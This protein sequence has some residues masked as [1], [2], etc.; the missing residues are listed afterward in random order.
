[1]SLKSRLDMLADVAAK[2]PKN[3]FA[4]YGYAMELA[5]LERLDEAA[6]AFERLAADLPDYVPTYLQ[7]GKA[8]E[9]LGRREAARGLYARGVAAA[10][11]ARNDHAR[12]E[13]EAALAN[14]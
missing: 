4:R 3:A 7:G 14:A 8:L 6:A 9:R 13:L 12:E 2:D 5:R 10:T 1:M 11:R